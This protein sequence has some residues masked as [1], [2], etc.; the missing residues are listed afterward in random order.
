MSGI[1][2][3][4]PP[5][6][7]VPVTGEFP[8]TLCE[9]GM[10]GPERDA[11]VRAVLSGEKTATSSLLVEWE[12]EG[13]ALPE[14]GDRAT[15]VDSSGGPVAVIELTAVDVVRLADVGIE[16]ARAE[17]EGFAGVDDWRTVHE[18]FW[19]EHSL[20]A[21]PDE[22]ISSLDDDTAVVVEH[23]RLIAPAVTGDR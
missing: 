1:E 14:A 3:G 10:P 19:N 21:L 18:R 6:V 8:D 7:A 13:E 5:P 12:Y 9:L 23:F 4:G 15:V 20:P 11:L 16:V 22:V 2:S 17:G